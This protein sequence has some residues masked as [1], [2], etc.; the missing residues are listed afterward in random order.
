LFAIE[1]VP[2]PVNAVFHRAMAG[3][4]AASNRLAKGILMP[5]IDAAVSRYL[6]GTGRQR[7]EKEDVAQEVLAHLYE[8]QWAKLRNFDATRGTLISF[9]WVVV[10]NWIRDHS[11]NA[12]PPEPVEN[13]EEGIPPDSGPEG[14]AQ[15]AQIV[16]R[17]M[18]SLDEE[19][20]LLFQ[21]VHFQGLE[22]EEIAARLDVSMDAAYKRIQRM[23]AHVK[24]A[25]SQPDLMPKIDRRPS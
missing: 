22:R 25:L 18:A 4:R 17:L 9:V 24:A 5:A 7:F 16:E 12:P 14:K 3:D 11:R 21:W 2:D 6:F 23:E 20:L 1:Q 19:Q 8:N 10:R 13:P 15:L